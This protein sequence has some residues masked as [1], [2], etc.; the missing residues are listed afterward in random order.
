[1]VQF[2]HSLVHYASLNNMNINWGYENK[3]TVEIS[4]SKIYSMLE[5]QKVDFD[6][7]GERSPE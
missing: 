2:P 6:R 5:T 4:S 3:V 1:M 7:P